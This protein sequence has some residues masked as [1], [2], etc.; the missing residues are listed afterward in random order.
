MDVRAQKVEHPS[1]L[2]GGPQ[3]LPVYLIS[4]IL[5]HLRGD[6]RAVVNATL[7]CKQWYTLLSPDRCY[8]YP[9][10]HGNRRALASRPMRDARVSGCFTPMNPW[11][12]PRW[13]GERLGAVVSPQQGRHSQS[14]YYKRHRR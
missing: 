5:G 3:D 13:E 7:V 10:G 1:A 4:Q 9:Y 6:G 8:I 14:C 2:V 12:D 11:F